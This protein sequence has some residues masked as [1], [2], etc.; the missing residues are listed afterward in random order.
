MGKAEEAIQRVDAQIESLSAEQISL[1]ENADASRKGAV[2]VDNL[3]SKGRYDMQLQA[4]IS[5]LQQARSQLVQERSRRQKCL[6]DA[7]AELKRFEKL[8]KNDRAAYAAETVRREQAAADDDAGRR[9]TLT[10][11]RQSQS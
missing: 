5:T 7:E 11:Q 3:L 1:R 6:V 10:R 4:E 8:E 9:H 2:S